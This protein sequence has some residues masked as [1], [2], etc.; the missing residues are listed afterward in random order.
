M[1]GIQRCNEVD[2]VQRRREPD[3]VHEFGRLRL[4]ISHIIMT[5]GPLATHDET[6]VEKFTS[7]T[8]S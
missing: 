8:L 5:A 1:D 6:T 3:G 4:L 2:G 7:E